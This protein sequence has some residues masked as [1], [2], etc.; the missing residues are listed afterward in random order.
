MNRMPSAGADAYQATI[1]TRQTFPPSLR[2]CNFSS[3]WNISPI[4]R[5]FQLLSP[6]PRDRERRDR[7]PGNFFWLTFCR[8]VLLRAI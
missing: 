8:G 3:P 1:I 2:S 6:R 4:P 5:V 7:K